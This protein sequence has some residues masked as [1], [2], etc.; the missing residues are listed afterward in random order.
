MTYVKDTAI[1][2]LGMGVI[3]QTHLLAAIT[4]NDIS[5]GVDLI[6]KIVVAVGTLIALF[7]KKKTKK[8]E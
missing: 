1:G 3:D 7:K 2:V 5:T 4:P 8:V 6:S